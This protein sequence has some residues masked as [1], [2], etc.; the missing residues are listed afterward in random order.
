MNKK[1]HFLKVLV[2]GGGELL[3][4]QLLALSTIL[5]TVGLYSFKIKGSIIFY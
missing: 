2:A 5:C 4:S 3:K 1:E